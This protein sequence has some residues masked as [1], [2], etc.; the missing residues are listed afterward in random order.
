MHI[1]IPECN[2]L[3]SH[4]I[5][6]TISNSFVLIHVQYPSVLLATL[7]QNLI[8]TLK[9]RLNWSIKFCF[10]RQKFDSSS[11]LKMNL[12]ILPNSLLFGWR[13]ATYCHSIMN[14]K[15]PVFSS[16]AL[17][18]PAA[19]FQIHERTHKIFT[20]TISKCKM[21]EKKSIRGMFCSTILFQESMC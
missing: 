3:C 5:Q 14:K 18:L 21:H 2:A 8:K 19:S 10:H 9:K 16:S 12:D 11:D 15:K 17:K 13:A 6:K 7:N 1:W 20:K 4:C